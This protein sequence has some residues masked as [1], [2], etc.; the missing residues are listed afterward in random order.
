[1]LHKAVVLLGGAF[2]QGLEPMRAMCRA[3]LHRPLLHACSHSIGCCHIEGSAAV[4]DVTHLLIYIRGKIVLH[5]L[6]VEDILCKE[7]AWTLFAIG[8][9]D[10][11]FLECLAYNL[12]PKCAGH[13]M[14]DDVRC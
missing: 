14:M 6:S 5:L 10:G 13:I 2:G 11:P 1:M 3:K 8:H 9:I 12:E 4:D 7:L